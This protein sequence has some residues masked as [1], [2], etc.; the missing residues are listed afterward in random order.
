MEKCQ[1]CNRPLEDH[2]ETLCSACEA[3]NSYNSKMWVKILGG[4]ISMAS[5]A[6][7]M[8]SSDD[9]DND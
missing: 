5:L 1:Q 6:W 3:D 7:Y 9:E 8:L 4:V 2:E